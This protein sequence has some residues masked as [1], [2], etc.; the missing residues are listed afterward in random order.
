MSAPDG[1]QREVLHDA[2]QAAMVATEDGA[3]VSG[4]FLVAEM[5]TPDGRTFLAYRTGDVNGVGLTT[6]RGLG[7]LHSAVLAVEQ[8]SWETNVPREPD[9]D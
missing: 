4:W 1:E 2:I 5:Q 7:F 8:E 3:L 9:D 6:W